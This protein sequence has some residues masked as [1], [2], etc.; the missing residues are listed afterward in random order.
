MTAMAGAEP[1]A[2][3]GDGG[4]I[5]LRLADLSQRRAADEAGAAFLLRSIWGAGAGK[6]AIGLFVAGTGFHH[7]LM[8]S[9]YHFDRKPAGHQR[10]DGTAQPPSWMKWPE[11]AAAAF[12][13]GGNRGARRAARPLQRLAAVARWR[14]EAMP[15]S[16]SCCPIW[17]GMK[18]STPSAS[19]RT[20]TGIRASS[21]PRYYNIIGFLFPTTWETAWNMS[22]RRSWAGRRR[23]PDYQGR[24]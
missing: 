12:P 13:A 2:R 18:R 9:L 20:G 16:A 17:R 7:L 24:H 8:G 10:R 19:S 21:P 23:G 1:P 11:L 4:A 22:L 5:A 15:R 3:S 6:P 14:E